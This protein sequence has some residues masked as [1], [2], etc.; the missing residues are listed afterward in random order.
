MSELTVY[1]QHDDLLLTPA[2]TIDRLIDSYRVKQEFINAVFRENLD[3]GEIPGSTKPALLKPGAEKMVSLFG[4]SPAF[5]DVE[6]I[7]DWTGA[8]HNG[9]P[10][11]YY[12]IRCT[13]HHRNG[14]SMGSADGSCN[15]W[16]KKYRYRWMQESE[17]PAGMDKTK[18]VTRGGKISE[19]AFAIEKAETSGQY[20][21]P[22]EYWKRFTDAIANNTAAKTTRKTKTGKMMDAWEID[23][24]VYQVPN[25][26]MAEQVNT[27]LKMAQKR[28]LIAA[29]LIVT[30]VSDYFT[31]D[32]DD[33]VDGSFI[34]PA[35]T[36]AT[37][38]TGANGKAHD[39][40]PV[41]GAIA[42]ANDSIPAHVV[43][44]QSDAGLDGMEQSSLTQNDFWKA[45]NP[46]IGS[47]KITAKQ[48]NDILA[49]YKPDWQAAIDA[50]NDL[51][52]SLVTP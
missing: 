2:A 15:S 29:V 8:A 9:E 30:G 16:E 39:H 47:K 21:K 4:L 10:F 37:Q 1:Q 42:A 17:V 32:L 44:D 36:N 3:F 45:A 40:E 13:L 14:R 28:A 52:I 49:Q 33:F 25:P 34:T 48:A 20:G 26:D 11:F 35:T 12:R 6:K 27:V 7:E 31:Q 24:T 46:M 50:L 18:L 19:F 41:E 43:I 22:A 5:E 51:V 23:S 38:P